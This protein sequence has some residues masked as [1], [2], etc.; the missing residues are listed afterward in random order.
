[1]VRYLL[2]RRLPDLQGVSPDAAERTSADTKSLF[3]T[4]RDRKSN[5]RSTKEKLAAL[6]AEACRRKYKEIDY[7]LEIGAASRTGI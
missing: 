5:R 3:L 1:M 2:Y 6:V 4:T 7:R